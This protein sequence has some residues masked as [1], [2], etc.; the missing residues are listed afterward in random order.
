MREAEKAM[1]PVSK[2]WIYHLQKIQMCGPG[3]KSEDCVGTLHKDNHVATVLLSLPS[4]HVGG[5]LHVQHQNETMVLSSDNK[6]PQ[7]NIDGS[8]W[9]YGAFLTFCTHSVQEIISGWQVFI[10]YDVYEEGGDDNQGDDEDSNSDEDDEDYEDDVQQVADWLDAGEEP[11][12]TSNIH[13]NEQTE[14]AQAVWQYMAKIPPTHGVAFF[15]R[16][17][18]SLPTLDEVVLKGADRIIYN[19][20]SKREDLSVSIQ[21]VLG[22]VG[23]VNREDVSVDFMAVSMKDFLPTPSGNDDADPPSTDSADGSAATGGNRK[24]KEVGEKS[25]FHLIADKK[26]GAMYVYHDERD[27]DEDDQVLNGHYTYFVGCM[28]IRSVE[29]AKATAKH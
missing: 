20:F 21:G 10:I 11:V 29:K 5:I 9:L 14:L 15:L 13:N 19:A 12:A 23:V 8:R 25:T 22:Y 16:H 2:K 26:N 17:R 3:G 7:K 6:G 24:R 18:Y 1:K 28:L 27:A 4:E